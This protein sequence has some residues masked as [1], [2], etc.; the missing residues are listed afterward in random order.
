MVISR[1]E[2]KD[3]QLHVFKE[4]LGL[5][6]GS[7][8]HK[9]CEFDG[10]G[11]MESLI[12]LIPSEVDDLTYLDSTKARALINKGERGLI[13]ALQ[14]LHLKRKAEGDDKFT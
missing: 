11:D 6:D 1:E 7:N 10:I 5:P 4:I 8:I 13:F 9:A 2:K 12:T 3:F 14:A